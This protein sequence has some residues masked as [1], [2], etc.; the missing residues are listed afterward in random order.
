M[1]KEEE[2]KQEEEVDGLHDEN[3][4]EEENGCFI[5][6]PALGWLCSCSYF[7]K[8]RHPICPAVVCRKKLPP[9]FLRSG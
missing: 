7:T 5:L 2:M 6:T 9:L 4:D 3:K 8:Q 1:K